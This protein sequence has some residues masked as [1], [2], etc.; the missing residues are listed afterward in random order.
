MSVL[1]INSYLLFSV[2]PRFSADRFGLPGK[3]SYSR[4]GLLLYPQNRVLCSFGN[5]KF[6]DRLRWNL[7]L[8]LPSWD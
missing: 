1:A 5:T 6:D 3:N 4:R 7:D 2:V 8:L